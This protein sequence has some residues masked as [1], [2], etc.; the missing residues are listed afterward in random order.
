MKESN[1]QPQTE[2]LLTIGETADLWKCCERTVARKIQ[3]GEL[4]FVQLG[5]R[6]PRIPESAAAKF[7]KERTKPAKAGA[8]S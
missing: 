4:E 3:S 5:E 1:A 8:E 2:R 6:M 7:V